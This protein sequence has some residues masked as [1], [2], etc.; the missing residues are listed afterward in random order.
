MEYLLPLCSKRVD[1]LLLG[2]HPETGVASAV[3][4]ENKQWT[5]GDIESVEELIV[6]VGGRR[7]LHPQQ[8]VPQY[9][10]YLSDFNHL[11]HS[12]DLV[13]S[14]LAYLHNATS[15]E[16]ASLRSAAFADLA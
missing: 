3:V 15:T 1:V 10:E 2:T 6:S 16:L 12:N 5:S 11:A 13:I 7:L 4:W 8:Q 9:V 14:G